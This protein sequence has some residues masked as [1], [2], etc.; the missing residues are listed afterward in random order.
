MVVD[1]QGYGIHLLKLTASLP[2]E[3]RPNLVEQ[4]GIRFCKI[5]SR[6]PIIGLVFWLPAFS[7]ASYFHGGWEKWAKRIPTFAS[8][9][10]WCLIHSYLSEFTLTEN[11]WTF[12]MPCSYWVGISIPKKLEKS[13]KSPTIQQVS[14]KKQFGL[15]TG[16]FPLPW[17]W[18]K[19]GERAII[20]P[21]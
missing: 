3:N 13:W 18:E 20:F 16:H 11:V 8:D 21:W 12:I 1:F 6:H 15:E 19:N 9:F 4:G 17:L 5:I 2:H 7:F 10:S 14:T